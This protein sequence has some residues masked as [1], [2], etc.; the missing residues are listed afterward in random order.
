MADTNT[1]IEEVAASLVVPPLGDEPFKE[2]TKEQSVPKAPK[3]ADDDSKEVSNEEPEGSS[4]GTR[5]DS[6]EASSDDDW[7]AAFLSD[8][9]TSENEQT[10]EEGPD[11]EDDGDPL[12]TSELTAD[13]I[14][15][16]TKLTVT[17]DGEEK[18]VTIGELRRRYA[19]EGAIEK[20]LQE[21]TEARRIAYKQA[22]HN[23]DQ[24]VNIVKAVS[25]ILFTPQTQPPDP[26]LI[27]QDQQ[28][29]LLQKE[30]YDAEQQM[31][32]KRQEGVR[33]TLQQLNEQ[34]ENELNEIRKRESQ[35]LAE[36]LPI[37]RDPSKGPKF[38]DAFIKMLTEDYG[39]TQEE[40]DSATD[41]K[42]FLV[43]ADA[44]RYH[45]MRKKTAK[46]LGVQK[47]KARVVP[48]QASKPRGDSQRRQY[49]KA[50]ARAR[51]TG[52]VDDIAQTLVVPQRRR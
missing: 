37:L 14:D 11:A 26:N 51:E 24:M 6:Q 32:R 34:V 16:N 52:S 49:Q 30:Q 20:R 2:N 23:R 4:E 46:G 13:G 31:I 39:F 15:D 47:S 40:I 28:S 36:K 5:D 22:E 3:S 19:G 27:Y 48:K 25:D 43:A 33:Q 10:S 12:D 1:N 50:M 35:R 8:E 21:A 44:L 18:E 41:H 38:R 17:V 42:V 45:M 29:Y 9:Q 7:S